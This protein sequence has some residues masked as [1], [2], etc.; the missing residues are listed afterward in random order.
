MPVCGG[1]N[2]DLAVCT[3]ADR[4]RSRE[5]RE[6][7]L[8][9]KRQKEDANNTA[10]K[11][12]TKQLSEEGSAIVAALNLSLG[13]KLD[14]VDNKISTL[15]EEVGELR[16]QLSETT[17]RVHKNET[18]LESVEVDI[19]A[20]KTELAARTPDV[21][22]K[23]LEQTIEELR[24][25]VNGFKA[26]A[27]LD[28]PLVG[29]TAESGNWQPR[30]V[31]V[32][33]FAPFGCD[34]S[35]KITRGD[36]DTHTKRFMALLPDK[37]KQRVTVESPFALSHQLAFRITGGRDVCEVVKNYF[38]NGIINDNITIKDRELMVMIQLSEARKLTFKAFFDAV[39]RVK[40]KLEPSKIDICRR[41]LTIFELP[42]YNVI[43]KIPKE[44]TTMQWEADT[45]SRLGISTEATSQ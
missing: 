28:P 5:R 13:G 22:I 11:P 30:Y 14:T 42:D 2:K 4:S 15:G 18:R 35:E 6:R 33:G 26:N 21:K 41:T 16:K 20:I 39:E 38:T 34:K 17:N 44:T 43:G 3:C 37:V 8:R 45:C 10:K 31:Y 40:A 19:Q 24:S 36:Y 27:V 12:D 25:I 32:R 23:E 29:N 9:E 1:C 7:E